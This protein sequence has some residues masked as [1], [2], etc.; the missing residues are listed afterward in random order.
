MAKISEFRQTP[1]QAPIDKG[2]EYVQLLPD[3]GSNVTASNPQLQPARRTAGGQAPVLGNAPAPGTA[4]APAGGQAPVPGDAPA[5]GTAA[6]PAGGQA[7]VPG[8]APAPG[9]AAAPAGGQAPV[10]G[11]APA[12]G[13]AAAPAGGQAPVPGDGPTP[14]AAVAGK[15]N[16]RLDAPAPISK[17]Q[18]RMVI[19][20]LNCSQ[21]M[22]SSRYR[23]PGAE[24]VREG[25]GGAPAPK[26]ELPEQMADWSR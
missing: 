14:G 5:P 16:Q 17:P 13:T 2:T 8:D 15:G 20:Y 25:P 9:T 3:G 12:P 23:D 1:D 6:A 4:A 19:Q 10:S 26:E 18:T 21:V 24:M 11:D 7:P 22:P